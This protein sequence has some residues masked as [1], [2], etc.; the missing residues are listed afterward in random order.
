MKI[1]KSILVQII[2]EELARLNELTTAPVEKPAA[3]PFEKTAAL[4]TV[5]ASTAATAKAGRQ[6]GKEQSAKGITPKERGTIKQ[7]TDM[8]VGASKETNILSGTVIAK[9]RHLAIDLQKIL[10]QPEQGDSE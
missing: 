6:A 3:A 10:S 4:G 8:L 1:T 5:A 2:K 7:L 9:I